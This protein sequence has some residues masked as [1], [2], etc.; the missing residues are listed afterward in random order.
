M[1]RLRNLV[2][3]VLWSAALTACG[4]G[5]H[6]SLPPSSGSVSPLKAAKAQATFRIDVPRTGAAANK[7]SAQYVSPATTQMAIDIK[8][9]GTSIAGYP[10]T[11]GLTATS[12]GCSSTL[13]NTFCQ[14]S[15]AIAPGTY[16]TT[17]TTEDTN[18]TALSSAQSI[19]F[20]IIAGATNLIPITLSG[21]P[22]ALLVSS[23]STAVHGSASEGFTVYGTAAQPI[24]VTAL[25]ADGNYIVGPGSPRYQISSANVNGY[26]IAPPADTSPN[27]IMVTPPGTNGSGTTL[28]A[29]ALFSDTT[30]QL[31]GAICSA[32]FTMKND[33]QTLFVSS[34][35][36]AVSAFTAPYTASPTVITNGI[37]TASALATDAAGDLF[38]A[39]EGAQ[40][41]TE[42]APPYTG[43]PLVTISSY[44]SDPR[45][46]LIDPRG[47]LF[48]ANVDS[49]YVTI[50]APPYT[51]MPQAINFG[52]SSPVALAMDPAGDLFI[53][54]LGTQNVL[55]FA[56]PYSGSPSIIGSGITSPYTLALDPSGDLFVGNCAGYVGM[57]APPYTSRTT[58]VQT[59]GCAIALDR[60]ANLY[61]G[62]Q[63]DS[64]VFGFPAPYIGEPTTTITSGVSSPLSLV[65]DG[66]GSLF[67]GN[68]NGTVTQYSSPRNGGSAAAVLTEAS[69]GP[70]SFMTIT[71]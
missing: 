14:L 48:V 29:T 21:V 4:A 22:D 42:Y 2:A 26:S 39:N 16:T 30:C 63:E 56:P 65:I 69:S 35:S 34:Q 50:Y 52:T 27:T 54:N 1:K 18:G 24:I 32:T 60:S 28:I 10:I 15:I 36:D 47:N 9:S 64:T 62:V 68:E 12:G 19:G 43:A 70:G 45:A 7:R 51:G 31:A 6:S 25:D 55:E 37:S 5:T 11:V 38:V 40:T 59:D 33:I 67:V 13:A 53:A 58:Y 20:T 23:G 61:V 44:V 71:P 46:L 8:Q 66:M 49:S 17:L 3:I 41:V 57:Y